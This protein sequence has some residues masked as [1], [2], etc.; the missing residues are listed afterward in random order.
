MV[1]Q[2]TVRG[3]VVVLAPGVQLE[4]GLSVMVQASPSAPPAQ[5]TNGQTPQVRNGVPIFPRTSSTA[6]VDLDLVNKLRD[7]SP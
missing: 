7:E 3:G 1:Y 4:E 5:P 2:G 6:T